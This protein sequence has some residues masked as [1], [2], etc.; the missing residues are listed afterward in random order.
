[1]P[2]SF[3]PEVTRTRAR[4]GR[5]TQSLAREDTLAP[6]TPRGGCPPAA[7]RSKGSRPPQRGRVAPLI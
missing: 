6:G 4:A 7:G 1:M 3:S 5:I 2:S